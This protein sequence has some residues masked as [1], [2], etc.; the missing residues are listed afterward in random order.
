MTPYKR[1]SLYNRCLFRFAFCISWTCHVSKW[2]AN[3]LDPLQTQLWQYILTD[4]VVLSGTGMIKDSPPAPRTYSTSLAN[5][6]LMKLISKAFAFFNAISSTYYFNIMDANGIQT[7]TIVHKASLSFSPMKH[8]DKNY[9]TT[10][11]MQN[12]GGLILEPQ[13][14]C[15]GNTQICSLPW[16]ARCG[17][18]L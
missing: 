16:N 15:P 12:S 1:R 10:C 13:R 3:Q 4:L 2:T 14:R 8:E 6:A 9:Q 7:T 11:Q 17:N 5:D 18:Q